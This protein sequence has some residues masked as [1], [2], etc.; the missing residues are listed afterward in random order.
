MYKRIVAIII[1]T[2]ML[3]TCVNAEQ[4]DSI[5]NYDTEY[6]EEQIED[7]PEQEQQEQDNQESQD[8]NIQ[9]NKDDTK[10]TNNQNNQ[11]QQ[12]E[13]IQEELTNDSLSDT[14]EEITSTFE[15]VITT[16]FSTEENINEPTTEEVSIIDTNTNTDN[17]NDNFIENTS[18]EVI[19][20]IST[21]KIS[22][23]DTETINS[24]DIASA[25][26][27]TYLEPDAITVT[28]PT[29]L[30]FQITPN[31]TYT[32][33]ADTDIIENQ[34]DKDIEIGFIGYEKIEGCDVVSPDYFEDWDNLSK[35][36]TSKYIALGINC[37]RDT[38]WTPSEIDWDKPA[39]TFIIAPHQKEEV[40]IAVKCGKAWESDCVLLYRLNLL[41]KVK[42]DTGNTVDTNGIDNTSQGY[43]TNIIEQSDTSSQEN[44]T[45]NNINYRDQT[46]I[47]N[48]DSVYL[49][50]NGSS[51]IVLDKI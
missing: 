31:N 28:V 19:T 13:D 42:E 24:D 14:L 7:Q 41:V 34:S 3:S 45:D 20:E 36:D 22:T 27:V 6:Q 18:N 43:Q 38:Y 49:D 16:E 10:N 1:T 35:S 17:S 48:K 32:I 44:N 47:I 51:D 5:D 12:D 9:E 26:A 29:A 40:S 37:A 2:A 23:N 15:E 25:G 33:R 8:Q 21:E 4:L 39:G 30:Y 11:E 46:D 50:T